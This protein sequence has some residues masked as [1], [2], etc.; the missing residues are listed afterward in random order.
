LEGYNALPKQEKAQV[1]K[2]NIDESLFKAWNFDRP[3]A[4]IKAGQLDGDLST[5]KI[6]KNTPLC[7][8]CTNELIPEY[9]KK[10]IDHKKKPEPAA[11]GAINKAYNKVKQMK[12]W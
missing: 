3:Q 8:E 4:A 11:A 7:R 12:F 10:Y 2:F 6:H 5:L 9:V 1:K